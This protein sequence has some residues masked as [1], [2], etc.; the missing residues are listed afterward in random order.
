MPLVLILGAGELGTACALRLTRAGFPVFLLE[1][2]K[3]FDIYQSRTF[4]SAV[5]LGNRTIEGITVRTMADALGRDIVPEKTSTAE[6]VIFES[7]NR[8]IALI[9]PAQWDEIQSLKFHYVVTTK[10]SLFSHERFA[11]WKVIGFSAEI[12]VVNYSYTVC[13]QGPFMGRVIYPFLAE[14]IQRQ[15]SHIRDEKPG[16]RIKTPIEGIFEARKQINDVVY[17]KDVLAT[18]TGIPILS[19]ERGRVTGLLNS[20]VI[21]PAGLEFMEI[22]PLHS[23]VDGM[24]IPKESFTLAGA[25]LEAILFDRKLNADT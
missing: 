4:S 13:D 3:P 16:Q 9:H 24:V 11:K 5:Y 20:G 17:E 21:V 23:R 19:P 6:F 22:S 25:V 15:S 14:H 10:A 8:E 1:E 2:E 7:A 18:I 12:D